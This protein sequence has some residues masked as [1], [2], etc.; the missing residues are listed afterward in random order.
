MRR[1]DPQ[2]ERRG[3]L[4]RAL[5]RFRE[6]M[7]GSL[8]F[9]SRPCGKAGCVCARGKKHWHSSFQLVLYQRGGTP[10]TYHVP[11][12]Q[13][14]EVKARIALR[15]EFEEKVKG[16]LRINLERWLSGKKKG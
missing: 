9:R 4:A 8:V 16:I 15:K 7:P 1:N 2:L 11:Q 3:A 6:M 14:P 13:V 10:K 12:E 5:A